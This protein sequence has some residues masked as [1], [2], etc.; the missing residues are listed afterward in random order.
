MQ[1][2]F[3]PFLSVI[4]IALLITG[5]AS[6]TVVK[7]KP[8][9]TIFEKSNNF[10]TDFDSGHLKFSSPPGSRVDSLKIDTTRKSITIN[11]NKQF[12]YYPYRP[13]TVREIYAAVKNYFGA[14]F[15]NYDITLKTLNHPIEDL[16]PNY[17]RKNSTQYD[18]SRIPLI[19]KKR[20]APVIWNVSKKI[21]PSNGLYNR[22][23]VV[24]P[25]HG[26]YYNNRQDRWEW[27]RPRLFQ[28]VE[29]LIPYSF[30]IPYLVPMLENAGAN[31]FVPRER[32][33]QTNEVV[34]DNDTPAGSTSGNYIEHS[35]NKK[36]Q[37][38]NG[39]GSAFEIGNTPYPVDYNPFLHGTHRIT[40]AD[41]MITATAIWIPNIPEAGEYAV[42]IS[43]KASGANVDDAHYI[44]YHDGIKTD[45][46]VNQQIGGST[47][48]FLGKY[49]FK[50]GY[51]PDSDKVILVNESSQPGRIISADAVR[52]GGGM[53]VVMRNGHTSG[54]PKF[55][56]GSRYYLQY[57]GMPDTLVYDLHKDKNDYVDD[58][59]SRPEY[60]NYLYGDPFGPNKDRKVKGLGIPIDL[61]MA[62]HTDA[63]ITHNDTTVGTLSIYSLAGADTDYV[64]PD[65]VSRMANRDLADIMQTQ[66]VKDIRAKYD[67]TWNR[68]SLRDGDY[69]ESF[70]PNVPAVL[71]ELLSHQ[72]FLDM[73]FMQDP[74]FRFLVSRAIYKG[75]LRFLSIQYRFKYIVEPLPVTN[76]N[77]SMNG[78]GDVTLRWKP[79]IDSLE[80]TAVPDKYILYTRK[81]GGD[82]DNGVLVDQPDVVFKNVKPG[83]IYSYKVTAV[84]GGGESFPSEV[85][86]VCRMKDDRKPVLIINDFTRIA[87]P[88]KVVSDKFTGFVNNIDPGMPYKYD[89]SFT[90]AQYNFD[91]ASQYKNNDNP[92]W[93]AS[94]ANYETKVIAGNTF[95]YPYIHGK[96]IKAC[97]YPF[98]STS[99]KAVIEDSLDLSQY[100]FVDLILGEQ[101]T[102]HWE[103]AVEDSIRGLRFETFPK[104]LQL[105]ITKYCESGGNLF[106]SGSY[107]GSDL[108]KYMPEANSN[109]QFARDVLKFNWDTDHAAV[110]GNVFSAD[111]NFLHKFDAFRFNSQFNDKI[112][113]VTAPD[114]ITNVKDSETI[115]R[116]TENQFS[117]GTAYKG[118]YGVIVFGFPFETIIEQSERDAIMKAVLSYFKL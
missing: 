86:S 44:V 61:S 14:L 3:I 102:T 1:K 58:Y 35:Y 60:V 52:F 110:T 7:E 62:F 81:N 18:Y 63:G 55:V 72:N 56:E 94:H 88:A 20:S 64:Y 27:Q 32:D 69:S 84:N 75:M 48:E 15:E 80:P 117:A 70:R 83:I 85:L 4:S 6:K 22:N 53:G 99:V 77:S 66:I 103:R 73:T 42:Y 101:K 40:L 93:G 104:K 11:L 8:I 118:K 39:I 113:A 38:K 13:Q 87:P 49:K 45:F 9:P 21:V 78:L 95:D 46:R 19:T 51:N 57:M 17:Y 41:T 30:T 54:R 71:I 89:V 96:S 31:V 82:F 43:Y 26:W 37:W 106:V 36:H 79:T 90:G 114:A 50:K 91:S 28:S 116:Y 5:C 97:G 34:V 10:I 59:Q 25:S 29:D 109:I 111:S 76:F 33:V 112:Y 2:L 23:I 67:S 16:I 65:G 74:R 24:W 115:L 107:V 105:M 12:S 100:K 108:Y 92:G 98:V 68:R 47:W